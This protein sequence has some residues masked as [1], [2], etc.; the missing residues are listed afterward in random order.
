MM[1][2]NTSGSVNNVASNDTGDVGFG[3]S[4]SGDVG[5]YSIVGFRDDI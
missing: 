4:D 2:T 5:A 3:S 1:L